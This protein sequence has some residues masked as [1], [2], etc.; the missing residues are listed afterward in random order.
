MTGLYCVTDN[1]NQIYRVMAYSP[2]SFSFWIAASGGYETLSLKSYLEKYES[3]KSTNF[4]VDY[5]I[6]EQSKYYVFS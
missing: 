3:Y 6:L 5:P 4:L 2:L 1:K